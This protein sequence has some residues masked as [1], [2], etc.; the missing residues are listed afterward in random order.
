[1]SRAKTL[2][3]AAIAKSIFRNHPFFKYAGYQPWGWDWQ[4]FGACYPRSC[5]I[6]RYCLMKIGN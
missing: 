4:T 3:H 1:M 2:D 6:L 5:K